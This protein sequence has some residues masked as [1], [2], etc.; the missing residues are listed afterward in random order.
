V[1]SSTFCADELLLDPPEGLFLVEGEG[2]GEAE[3]EEEKKEEEEEGGEAIEGD[4]FKKD[5][6]GCE[7]IEGDGV[8]AGEGEEEKEEDGEIVVGREGEGE[9]EKEGEGELLLGAGEDGTSC[10]EGLLEPGDENTPCDDGEDTAVDFNDDGA[11]ALCEGVASPPAMEPE[12]PGITVHA[13]CV[14]VP[15]QESK[16]PSLHVRVCVSALQI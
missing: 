11:G 13:E 15:L 6:E 5:E 2:E 4:G 3:A 7:V 10:D 12:D 9:A 14:N 16:S 1:A 8:E